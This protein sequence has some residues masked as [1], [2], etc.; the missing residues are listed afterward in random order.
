MDTLYTPQNF[1]FV[2]P[3]I[4]KFRYEKHCTMSLDPP[5]GTIRPTTQ[6]S[7]YYNFQI[8]AASLQKFFNRYSVYTSKF[9]FCLACPP[10]ASAPGC[11]RRGLKFE[12]LPP[13]AD[14]PR[15]WRYEKYC[16]V[17]LLCFWQSSATFFR[18]HNFFVINTA[19]GT[20]LGTAD[21]VR[22]PLRMSTP[23]HPVVI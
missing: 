1:H 7:F 10:V 8:W 21:I 19:F 9:L 16:A 3:K 18:C 12:N 22:Q 14:L 6:Y 23:K 5:Q 20:F 2:S 13:K 4:W 17:S 11:G 15:A